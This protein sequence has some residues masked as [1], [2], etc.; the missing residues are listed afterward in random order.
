MRVELDPDVMSDDDFDD[1]FALLRLFAEDRHDWLVIDPNQPDTIHAYLVKHAPHRAEVYGTLAR[2]AFQNNMWRTEGGPHARDVKVSRESAKDHLWDLGRPA[3]F[4]V[5][6]R[7]GDG[8]FLLA[9]AHIFGDSKVIRA[10]RKRWLEFVQSGGSGEVPKVVRNEISAFLRVQRVGFLF[11]GDHLTP[12]E[13]SKHESSAAALR[14]EGALGHVLSLREIENYVPNRI[15]AA[16]PASGKERKELYSRIR[17][18]KKLTM[19]QRA[20]FDMK[21]GFSR[22]KPQQAAAQAVLY[23]SLDAQTRAS[24]NDGFGEGL[25]KLL[26]REAEADN[27]TEADFETLGPGI[28]DELRGLLALLRQII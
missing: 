17:H 7:E 8:A 1:V 9:V 11:D 21:H 18:I 28:C 20:H 22:Q 15:L 14:S 2:K 3:R 26:M 19:Q 12:D 23:A 4:V 24:L 27:V 13:Q 10:N 6:N 25:P 16:V 5:E